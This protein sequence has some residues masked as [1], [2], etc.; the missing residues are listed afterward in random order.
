M[1]SHRQ[2][3]ARL[4]RLIISGLLLGTA[5]TL[6]TASAQDATAPA[7]PAAPAVEITPQT[8]VAT[9]GGETITE[10]DISFAA[11]DLAQE[12]QQMPPEQR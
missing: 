10:A 9:V 11:Q 8:V 6:G 12:L 1:K 4:A 5:L 3:A 7:A 2:P